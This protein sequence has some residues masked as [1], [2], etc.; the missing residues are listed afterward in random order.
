MLETGPVN[1]SNTRFDSAF[2]RMQTVRVTNCSW[3]TVPHNDFCNYSLYTLGWVVYVTS[4]LGRLSLLPS[5]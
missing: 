2:K 3:Q 5:V 4:H 1:Q